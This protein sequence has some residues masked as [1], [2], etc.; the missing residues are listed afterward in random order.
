MKGVYSKEA[1]HSV[2]ESL[3]AMSSVF[4]N[5]VHVVYESEEDAIYIGV[6]NSRKSIRALFKLNTSDLINNYQATVKDIGLWDAKQFVN[7]LGK[8]E[9]DIYSD[10][11]LVEADDRKLVITCGKEKTDYYTSPLHLFTEIRLNQRRLKTENLTNACSFTLNGIDLK[12]LM[13]NINVFDDQDQITLKGVEGTKE[14]T[15]S[16]SSSSGSVYNR[17]DSVIEDVEVSTSF[18][19]RFPKTDIKGLL[20]CNDSFEITVFVGKKSVVEAAYSKN[21]YDM[22]FYFSPLSD[23]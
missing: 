22:R 7:I 12:K 14:V 5:D 8:Y 10:E 11:V 9:S 13:T 4:S 21:N 20:S 18:E 2:V 15:V 23:V 3:K 19:L 16:L 6:A 1:I 17:N